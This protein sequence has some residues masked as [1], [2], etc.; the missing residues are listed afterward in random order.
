[1]PDMNISNSVVLANG[2]RMPLLGLGV[3]PMKEGAETEEAVLTAF[4][5]GYRSIDTASIYAN[6]ASVGRAIAHCGIPREEIFI[7]TK[8][9]NSDQ[10][11]Q[12]TLKAFERSR[13]KLMVDTIDLYLIHWPVKGRYLE[14]WKAIEKLYQEGSVRAIGLSNFLI[15]HLK[16]ILAGCDVA[17]VIN[18]VEFH[19]LLQQKVLHQFCIDNKIQLEAWAPLGQ[20]ELLTNP[21]ILHLAYKYGKTPA[22]ILIRWDIQHRVV[23][24]P[25]SSR[26]QRIIENSRV[27]DF[28]ISS[29]DTACIDQLDENRRIGDDPDNFNF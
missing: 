17:P 10:G 24:I 8:V 7:T 26:S 9:W 14:T 25:K 22:Q 23:T 20:G 15:H 4:E 29:E 6:E 2:V 3:F 5:A 28:N 11:Y 13:K 19:P 1:M 12:S 16:D 27:F 18:Q 21:T